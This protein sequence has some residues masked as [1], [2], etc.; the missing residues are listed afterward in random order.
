MRG[1]IPLA[2]MLA[3]VGDSFFCFQ[4]RKAVVDRPVGFANVKA[5]IS[6]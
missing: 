6:L 4:A 1:H 5:H 3:V 2:E